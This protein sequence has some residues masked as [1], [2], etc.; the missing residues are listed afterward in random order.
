MVPHAEGG[1]HGGAEPEIELELELGRAEYAGFRISALT[2]GEGG[3]ALE[4]WRSRLDCVL[5]EAVPL[6]SWRRCP[7]SSL[8]SWRTKENRGR[9]RIE[10]ASSCVRG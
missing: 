6:P 5:G 10:E 3:A 1:K 2:A 7:P 9:P 4:K 8:T